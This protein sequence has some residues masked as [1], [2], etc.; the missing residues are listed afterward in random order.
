MEEIGE[1]DYGYRL[2]VSDCEEYGPE[3]R[4]IPRRMYCYTDWA[5]G[6]KIGM[7]IRAEG[8]MEAPEPERNPGGFDRADGLK[9]GMRIRAEGTMEAPEPERNPGGFDHRSFCRA[10]GIGGIFRADWAAPAGPGYSR[11]REGIRQIRL[12]LEGRL[13]QLT[14]GT[15]GG[16]LKAVLLGDRSDMDQALYELYR[17]N[18][19]SHVL[20]ISGLHVSILGLGLWKALRRCGFGFAA[21]GGAAG[22]FLFCYGLMTG[23]GPSVVRA[24]AMCGISFLAA[25][26]GRTYDLISALCI[27]ALALLWSWPCLLTQ[28]S[29]QLS[30]L[31]A[32]AVAFPGSF[33]IRRFKA[34]GLFQT[35][36]VS[37]SIQA[38]T[39]PAVLYHSFELP[40][41]GILLNLLVI[42]LMTYVMVS[43]LLGLAASL[44]SMKAGAALLG[45]A[46]YILGL[47]KAMGEGTQR[48]PG[49]SLVVGR[50][51]L[52]A[53]VLF[54]AGAFLGILL[55]SRTLEQRRS[56]MGE[57]TQR[58]PGA[59]LVVGRPSLAAMVLF[60][61]GAFLGILLASRTLEQRRSRPQAFLILCLFWAGSVFF[62]FPPPRNGLSAVFL[63]VGQG[64]GIFLACG[65]RTRRPGMGCLPY[66]WM[67]ARGMGSF[68]P[69]EEGPC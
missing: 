53:M 1:T 10:K 25:F 11:F 68:W 37:A 16:I 63:D 43:G 67:W 42:P 44:F 60:L 19:I 49:A 39:A 61:A 45:G 58:L 59:S 17:K 52:A 3:A 36:L 32:G 30:F 50:P 38:A 18:G 5:D 34:R 35:L 12:R 13:D 41:Y 28:A 6:L 40:V 69:A 2:M 22:A 8:T 64:D 29:F 54:L 46:H 47:Y 23:F 24:A 48:L 21:A 62:F 15:D 7:R 9:I 57:G 51:S 56:R 65:G 20:A 26:L 27:P 66:F 31:A 4:R 55:A 33:L 14:S